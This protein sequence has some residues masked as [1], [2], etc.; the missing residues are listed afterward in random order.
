MKTKLAVIL[1][2]VLLTAAFLAV[3]LSSGVLS[4]NDQDSSQTGYPDGTVQRQYLFYHGTR[5]IYAGEQWKGDPKEL[6]EAG[7]VLKVDN[8]H[9]PDE[10]GEVSRM[11]QG[12][13]Y[14]LRDAD[15]PSIRIYVEWPD[16]QKFAILVP[17]IDDSM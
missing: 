17:D 13:K 12:E 9:L 2:A 16:H 7:T 5:Y 15:G 4:N 8:E 6:T 10:E 14:Y 1:S 11:S 3:L